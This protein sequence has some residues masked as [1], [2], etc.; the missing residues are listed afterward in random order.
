[1]LEE[2]TSQVLA[3]NISI[4]NDQNIRNLGLFTKIYRSEFK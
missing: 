3:G 4:N 1:M 2:E